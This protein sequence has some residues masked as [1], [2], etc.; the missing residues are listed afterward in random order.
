MHIDTLYYDINWKGINK[1]YNIINIIIHV[2][3]NLNIQ[4][5]YVYLKLKQMI[6]L[7]NF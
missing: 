6:N 1:K 3:K 2:Q 7:S 4:F 5:N